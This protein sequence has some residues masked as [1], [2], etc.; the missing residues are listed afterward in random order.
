MH[1]GWLLQHGIEEEQHPASE[2]LNRVLRVLLHKQEANIFKHDAPRLAP[3]YGFEEKRYPAGG[4]LYQVLGVLLHK[5]VAELLRRD[6]TDAQ[7]WLLQHDVEEENGVLPVETSK[8]T[9]LFHVDRL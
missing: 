2:N 3:L 5:Q 6:S 7:G 8:K 4:D 9:T 1:Q